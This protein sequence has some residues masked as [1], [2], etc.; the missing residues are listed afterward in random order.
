MELVICLALA[1]VTL[2]LLLLVVWKV[3]C[4]KENFVAKNLQKQNLMELFKSKQQ[5]EMQNLINK[6]L[7]PAF[8][9]DPLIA[10]QRK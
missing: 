6:E 10:R 1:L 8:R 7:G 3:K 5:H 2:S 9:A 4:N